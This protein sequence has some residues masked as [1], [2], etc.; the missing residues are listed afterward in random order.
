MKFT[1]RPKQAEI[2]SYRSGTLGVSAVPGSGKTHT[3]AMLA[4]QLAEELIKSR[5]AGMIPGTE[6]E[7][8]VVT[9]SNAAVENFKSRIAGFL[10]E[11]GYVPGIGYQVRTLHSMAAEIIRGNGAQI[12]LDPESVIIESTTTEYLLTR[13]INN[14]S[15]PRLRVLFED[16]VNPALTGEKRDAK[17]E[18]WL[19][20]FRGMAQKVISEA[21]DHGISPSQL[22]EAIDR[23]DSFDREKMRTLRE[24]AGVYDA[25]QSALRDY[26]GYDFADLML[27][28]YRV[29]QTDANYLA[30]LRRRWPYIL[31]DEAQDSSLIQ[32]RV[33]R[34]LVGENG[35]WVR[36]GDPNQ[37]I[38]VTFTSSNPA[39]LRDFLKEALMQ[40]DLDCSG[41]STRTILRVANRL[42]R[43]V[44]EAHPIPA[45]RDA[46]V[47]PYVSMTPRGDAAPNPPDQPERVF[48]D[49]TAYS[50][51][52]E[53]SKI[54][55]LAIAHATRYPNETIAILVPTNG[56]GAKFSELIQDS[57]I[58][59][60]E[61]LT[62]TAVDLSTGKL[63][64]TIFIWLARP[65]LR[66]NLVNIFTILVKRSNELNYY[67]SDEDCARAYEIFNLF[68]TAQD[69]LYPLS[70]AS[71]EATMRAA[72]ASEFTIQT[73][74][75]FR[76]TA[77]KWLDLRNIPVDQLIILIAQD[78]FVTPVEL[79]IANRIARAVLRDQQLDPLMN[80]K[81]QAS[82]VEEIANRA[83]MNMGVGE[84]G[85][86][87]PNLY[88]GKIVVT[89]YHKAK[90]LEWDQVY[91]TSVNSYDFPIGVAYQ[92]DGYRESY[93][94][95]PGY[96]RDQLDPGAEIVEQMKCVYS[97]VTEV[98]YEGKASC[99]ACDD[100][101]M[102]RLRLLYVGITRA[103]KG[104]YVSWNTGKY[105][106]A[107]W[108]EAI[109]VRTLRASF[110]DPA[111]IPSGKD[112][113]DV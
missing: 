18:S 96:I 20:L 103:K 44:N 25:Y 45:F 4:A 34:E 78:V 38:N 94:S 11:R 92:E 59:S 56:R 81:T 58:E 87:E 77:R 22:R 68:P 74:I 88:R 57:P 60:I 76:E 23:L 39:Y 62:T 71:F 16:W 91:L 48:F 7:V 64:A 112:D 109:A 8:L 111:V 63:I 86:F 51:A 84:S 104:L 50:S 85:D 14:I 35:N 26:P 69:F 37:A 46:L 73:M 95:Q 113:R 17:F 1:P 12:G 93:M 83:N 3:L 9:F 102:E 10:S 49:P 82:R 100:Y 15:K 99:A 67:L 43:W 65:H 47:P 33:L 80:F 97:E 28:A 66:E 6:P 110:E 101:A 32:E 42:I 72:D 70:E 108:S 53:L 52:E 21:K 36:V 75:L 55:S 61:Y 41:R 5:P 19:K 105:D 79:S 90:G 13:I 40:V 27:N 54:V 31:E 89:T 24:L 98:Y 107:K 29:L 106:W 30:Q 2:L